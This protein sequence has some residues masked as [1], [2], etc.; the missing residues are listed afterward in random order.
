MLESFIEQIGGGGEAIKQ[1]G[2]SLV[3]YL[4]A[5]PVLGRG[6]VNIFFFSASIHRWAVSECLPVS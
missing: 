2:V 4:L 1:K 3:K 5:W 6:C